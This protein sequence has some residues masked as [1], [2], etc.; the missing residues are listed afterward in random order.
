MPDPELDAVPRQ[1]GLFYPHN[2]LWGRYSISPI[3]PGVEMETQG[4]EVQLGTGGAMLPTPS[5]RIPG[6]SFLLDL[7]CVLVVWMMEKEKIHYY[8]LEEGEAT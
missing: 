4:E 5:G 2:I 1:S 3:F 7:L 6:P 8:M